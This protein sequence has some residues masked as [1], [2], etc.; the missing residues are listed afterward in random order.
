ML[1]SAIVVKMFVF[2]GYKSSIPV[3][4]MQLCLMLVILA[5]ASSK[6]RLEASKVPPR[7]QFSWRKHTNKFST[8]FTS[9]NSFPFS[10]G[11][12]EIWVCYSCKTVV[13]KW[14]WLES[15]RTSNVKTFMIHVILQSNKA[16][17]S[18]KLEGSGFKNITLLF[19]SS[20]ALKDFH[21]H[22]FP[23]LS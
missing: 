12:L 17:F 20:T 13:W 10:H 19:L 1:Q 15:S 11:E 4:L 8:P 2:K 23:S 18:T 3:V 22:Y 21:H 5:Y 7:L 9:S 14:W 6:T 16:S